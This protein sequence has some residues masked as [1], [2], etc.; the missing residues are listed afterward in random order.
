MTPEQKEKFD[1][2]NAQFIN[3]ADDSSSNKLENLM[4][5]LI[6]GLFA[7]VAY[8]KFTNQL[9]ILELYAPY[10]FIILGLAGCVFV[11]KDYSKNYVYFPR[12]ILKIEKDRS[13]TL[14]KFVVHFRFMISLS[15]LILGVYLIIF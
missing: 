14:F 5:W 15:I 9:Q 11:K 7:F 13:P 8:T 12:Y 4:I 3:K 2:I 6:L 1:K 10:V